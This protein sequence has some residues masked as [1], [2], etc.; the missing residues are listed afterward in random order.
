MVKVGVVASAAIL[1]HGL[2]EYPLRRRT[3]RTIQALIAMR[4]AFMVVPRR[5]GDSAHDRA[6]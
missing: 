4:L 5:R 6:P 1:A 2:V 3:I